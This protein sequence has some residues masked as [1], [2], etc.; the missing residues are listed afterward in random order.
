LMPPLPPAMP[1]SVV[2][3]RMDS[4]PSWEASCEQL[5]EKAPATPMEN[6]RRTFA[7]QQSGLTTP[8][9]C[10]ASESEST[11]GFSME[12]A[13][14]QSSG[15]ESDLATSGKYEAFSACGTPVG[16]LSGVVAPPPGLELPMELP[17]L[18]SMLHR[19]R[20]CSMEKEKEPARALCLAG[21]L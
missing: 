12:E 6:Q 18:E 13:V 10:C 15:S 14:L 7:K 19:R 5:G 21:L 2:S 17:G 11:F 20:M 9:T 3:P 8:T 4:A 16:R 1:A